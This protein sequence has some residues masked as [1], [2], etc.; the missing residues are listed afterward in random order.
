MRPRAKTA[1]PLPMGAYMNE[2]F[3]SLVLYYGSRHFYLRWAGSLVR[4]TREDKSGRTWSEDM[5]RRIGLLVIVAAIIIGSAVSVYAWKGG[6]GYRPYRYH[7]HRSPSVVVF[8]RI[9]VP[10]G[11]PYLYP[12]VVVAPP[13]VYVQPPSQVYV[14]PPPPQPYWYYC[15]NPSGY[16]PYVQQ[17]PG[18]WRQV[19][20]TPPG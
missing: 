4:Y 14:Q 19:N 5:T 3:F 20:P 6:Y 2:D 10:F 11:M 12:P 9:V 8:P 17:C 15:D 18:G 1:N 16:Y 13:R 7:G